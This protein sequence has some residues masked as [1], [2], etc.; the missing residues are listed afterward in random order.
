MLL[1][2]GGA[3]IW[4]W[5][6]VMGAVH[7]HSWITWLPGAVGTVLIFSAFGVLSAKNRR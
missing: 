4:I 5:E 3:L 6:L 2:T 1:Y 7:I